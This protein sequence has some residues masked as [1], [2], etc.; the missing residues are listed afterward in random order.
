MS[1]LLFCIMF[2]GLVLGQETEEMKVDVSI[3]QGE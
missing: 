1:T 3:D 2:V